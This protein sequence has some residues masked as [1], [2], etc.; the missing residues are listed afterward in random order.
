VELQ[1]GV[2]KP[3]KTKGKYMPIAQ[4]ER[5]WSLVGETRVKKFEKDFGYPFP[6]DYLSFLVNQNGG[7]LIPSHS[8]YMEFKNRKVEGGI[9]FLY[10]L[11]AQDYADFKSVIKTYHKHQRRMPEFL[12]PI[13]T[14]SS[15]NQISI[16]LDKSRYGEVVLWDHDGEVEYDNDEDSWEKDPLSNC[17]PISKSFTEFLNDL[18]VFED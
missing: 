18:F 11:D 10:G 1:S 12:L 8:Y 14:D 6:K 13:G 3:N 9:R 4:I 17:Y 15:G 16:I 5:S 7:K 2:I